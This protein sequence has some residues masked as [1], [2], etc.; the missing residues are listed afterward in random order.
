MGEAAEIRVLNLGQ[1]HKVKNSS[2]CAI[3][4]GLHKLE[5]LDIRGCKLIRDCALR[6]I[7]VH[8]PSA[9]AN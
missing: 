5:C 7:I 3:A 2:L 1:C 4:K 6:E 8:C 9:H